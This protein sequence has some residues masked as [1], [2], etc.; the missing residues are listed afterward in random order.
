MGP[1][2]PRSPSQRGL[3][4]TP[5]VVPPTN[6]SSDSPAFH[7]IVS[8]D[9]R[10]GSKLRLF[11]HGSA[12]VSQIHRPNNKARRT[13]IVGSQPLPSPITTSFSSVSVHRTA[14]NEPVPQGRQNDF[15]QFIPEAPIMFPLRSGGEGI[16]L[17]NALAE[18]FDHLIGRDDPM[19]ENYTAPAISLHLE[20]SFAAV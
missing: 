14:G 15:D 11:Q 17:D 9:W 7:G 2:T 16:S 5:F 3:E 6:R 19:F 10:P 20:V 1:R 12:S 13:L 8:H 18:N 4:S